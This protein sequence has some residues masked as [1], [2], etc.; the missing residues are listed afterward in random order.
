MNSKLLL[1]GLL[2][3]KPTNNLLILMVVFCIDSNNYC[4]H[5]NW[6]NSNDRVIKG[7]L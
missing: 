2:V 4:E 5:A 3:L 1:N 7:D 6:P